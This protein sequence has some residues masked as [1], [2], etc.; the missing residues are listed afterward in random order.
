MPETH[1]LARRLGL[2][3]ATSLVISN[4]I[5]TGI[6]TTTGFLAGDLGSPFLVLL[7]WVVG[8]VCALLGALCYSELAINF[9][10]SGGEYVY[11]RH[12]YGRT[13]GFLNGWV[14]LVAGF[15]API[16]SAALACANYLVFLWPAWQARPW[17]GGLL[18]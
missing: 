8:A 18:Q 11:L 4:M 13:W 17:P 6:F 9:P 7:S 5:G 3:S 16:A 15:P 14:S 1:T 12:A 2:G 10:V